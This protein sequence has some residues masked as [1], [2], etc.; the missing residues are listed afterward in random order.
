MNTFTFHKRSYV[1]LSHVRMPQCYSLPFNLPLA[2]LRSQSS[3]NM[4]TLCA[5]VNITRFW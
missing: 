1:Y 4:Y 5:N 3:Y 2:G